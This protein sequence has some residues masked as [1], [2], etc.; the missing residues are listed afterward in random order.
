MVGHES[1]FTKRTFRNLGVVVT[2]GMGGIGRSIVSEFVAH[3][4]K[5]ISLDRQS[6]PPVG[7]GKPSPQLREM[8]LDLANDAA[9]NDCVAD[10]S[11]ILPRI[12]VLINCAG[13]FTKETDA[14]APNRDSWARTL[15]INA[16]A[17]VKLSRLLAPMLG[18]RRAG[19][20]VNIASVR[21]YTAAKGAI[22]YSVSKGMVVQ[23]TNVLAVELANKGIR[24]NCIAPGDIETPMNPLDPENEEQARLLARIPMERMGSGRDIANAALFL[25]SPLAAYIT[26]TTL[27]VDGGFLSQ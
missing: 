19:S 1:P 4:A 22:A 17:L 16:I 8:T 23:A 26:G 13:I 12:D 9:L 27:R 18:D 25:C 21:A 14:M 2:G 20:I 6:D 3:G 15:D 7:V 24:V 10:I 5:V 11:S